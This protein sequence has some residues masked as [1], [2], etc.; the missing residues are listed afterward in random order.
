MFLIC[1]TLYSVPC[2]YRPPALC[3]STKIVGNPEEVEAWLLLSWCHD[4]LS[5]TQ[6]HSSVQATIIKYCRLSGLNSYG[7]HKSEISSQRGK[8]LVRA[9]FLACT[10]T[11]LFCPHMALLFLLKPLIP[12]WDSTLRVFSKPNY[13]PMVM[14]QLGFQHMNFG[15]GGVTGTHSI[16][17][18]LKRP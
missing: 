1:E 17:T 10:D 6:I 9:L 2:S 5:K 8:L 14:K 13:L 4:N 18:S 3:F 16:I 12:P 7:G 15:V 11:P